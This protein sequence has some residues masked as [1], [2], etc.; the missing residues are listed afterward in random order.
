MAHTRYEAT[1]LLTCLLSHSRGTPLSHPHF[2]VG[3][4][5]Q[6]RSRVFKDQVRACRLVVDKKRTDVEIQRRSASAA[7]PRLCRPGRPPSTTAAFPQPPPQAGRRFSVCK[8][9]VGLCDPWRR[10][11]ASR[12]PTKHAVHRRADRHPRH[13]AGD[14]GAPLGSRSLHVL[15]SR[16][17][18]PVRP[19]R[20]RRAS[21]RGSRRARR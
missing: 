9:A 1:Y 8:R 14:V 12:E 13:R 11:K 2:P 16:G 19:A 18:A 21:G 20:T 3:H 6:L 5:S 15:P 10:Q 17:A 4:R 7:L